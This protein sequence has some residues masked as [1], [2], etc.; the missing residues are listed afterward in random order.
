MGEYLVPKLGFKKVG[1]LAVNNDWGRSMA[2]ATSEIMK[3]TGGEV[4]MVEYCAASEANFTPVLTR[5]K[6]SPADTM[7][8]TTSLSGIV[9][10]MKQYHELGMKMN[11]FIT[12]GM[13]AEQLV[14]MASKEVFEG[15]Y[16]FARYIPTAPPR[17]K[18]KENQEMIAAF[19]KMHPNI[20]AECGV[21]AGYD[22]IYIVAGAIER[23]GAPDS[24]KIRD[25]LEKTDYNGFLGKVR[26]DKNGHSQ[27]R[28]HITQVRNGINKVIYV[29][30]E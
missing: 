4:I 15:V 1:Y 3:N 19:E 6:N 5:I 13:S 7:F 28:C 27:P 2:K 12:S 29:L 16:F 25:A 23:G 21:A 20:I 26:F 17:G 14:Q 18:E 8:I 22:S 30:K 11:V 9:L 10:I 24:I